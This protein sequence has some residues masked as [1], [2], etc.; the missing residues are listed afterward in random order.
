MG[1]SNTQNSALVCKRESLKKVVADAPV[2]SLKEED[3]ERNSAGFP[4][5]QSPPNLEPWEGLP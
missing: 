2:V 4:N 5:G 3:A 1:N